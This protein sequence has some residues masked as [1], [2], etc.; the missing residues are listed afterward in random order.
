MPASV[1]IVTPWGERLGGAEEMLWVALSNMDRERLQPTV[2]FL[3]EGPFAGEVGSLGIATAVIPAG[4][5]RQPAAARRAI[6]RLRSLLRE[7][8]P[9]L[10][11]SWSA[12]AHLYGSVA[13]MAAGIGDRAIWWQHMIP[14][15]HWLDRI[16]TLLPAKAIGC[17]SGACEEGQSRLHPRRPTFVVHPGIDSR[18]SREGDGGDQL[19][20]QLGIP[21]GQ[22][23]VG[24][25]GRLQP[26]KGQDRFLR[27]LAELR[28]RHPNLHGLVVGG[29]AYGLSPEYAEGLDRLIS[30]LGLTDAVT[31]TGQVDDA[32]PYF[33]LM[34]IAVNA[35]EGEPFGIVLLEAMADGIPAVAVAMGGPA[36]IIEP[37]V[38]G[39]L[40]RTGEPGELARAIEALVVDPERRATMAAAAFTRFR[41][42]FTARKMT[43]SMTSKLVEL[44]G[45]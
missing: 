43:D 10:V 40:A 44:A 2:V 36:D 29:D 23:V 8:R 26:W 33:D 45:G 11:L 17:S 6:G 34:D 35:S 13:A 31:M 42:Q 37:G 20:A 19:R 25:V 18:S 30:E 7:R 12:K 38:T 4:R 21:A 22:V 15:G 14:D 39:E 41:D 1:V 24:I 32:R 27:A 5:L 28:T 9:D 3:G 16:A